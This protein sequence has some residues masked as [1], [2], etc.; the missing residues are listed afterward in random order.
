MF[1]EVRQNRLKSHLMI[2]FFIILISALGFTI[3]LI[4]DLPIFGLGMA[5]V[6]SIFYAIIV[7]SA[8]DKIILAATKANPVKK[9]KYPHLFHTIEGLAVAAGMKKPP[10]AYVIKDSA[11]NAYATGKDP[12]HS[13]I[14]VT[15]GLLDKL[16][17]QE[18]EGVIGHEMSHI[19]NYDIRTMMLAAVLVGVA[20]LLSDIILRSLLWGGLRGSSRKGEGGGIILVLIVVGI[21]LAI[22]TPV[23]AQLI[24]LSVSRKRE[25]M[26]DANAAILTRYPPGLASALEKIKKDPDPLVDTANRATAHLFIS[27]PFKN[28]E[29]F[30]TGIFS[31]HPDIDD[32]IKKLK[33][34]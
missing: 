3:G 22:L 21:I 33:E 27:S 23:I 30:F 4:W 32:R 6:F 25:Y 34:M 14:V 2:L 7:F 24:K 20:T 15:T 17:R 8:G 9:S 16:N 18:L 28:R 12:E 29:G 11:L 31:T 26:A 13:S 19:K 5:A 10:K 1:E